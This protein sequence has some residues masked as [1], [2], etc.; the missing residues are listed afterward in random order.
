MIQRGA[1]ILV[2]SPTYE[3]L[4]TRSLISRCQHRSIEVL[5][6]R[7]EALDLFHNEGNNFNRTDMT[8]W[9]MDYIY[10]P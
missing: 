9:E 1:R 10:I 2:Y 7:W 3:G 8:M 5:L 6:D 4:Q